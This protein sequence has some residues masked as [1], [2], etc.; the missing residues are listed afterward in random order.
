[1]PSFCAV[2]LLFA[3]SGSKSGSINWK[4]VDKPKIFPANVELTGRDGRQQLILAS[5][6]Q[7]VAGGRGVEAIRL[8]LDMPTGLLILDERGERLSM[9]VSFR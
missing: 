1:M 3:P 8:G 7:P 6:S 4:Q 5:F 9:C 2:A